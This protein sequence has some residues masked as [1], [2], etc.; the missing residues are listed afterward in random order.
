MMMREMERSGEIN[1]K[2][3]NLKIQ[4]QNNSQE[5]LRFLRFFLEYKFCCNANED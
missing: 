2:S 4:T 5:N 3:N 1:I